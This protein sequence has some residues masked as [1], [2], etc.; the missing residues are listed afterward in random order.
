M[1]H[2]H[3]FDWYGD[4]QKGLLVKSRAEAERAVALAPELA[5]AHAVRAQLWLFLYLNFALA[6]ADVDRALAISPNDP[7]SL[8]FKA[9]LVYARGKSSLAE[10]LSYLRRATELDPLNIGAWSRRGLAETWSGDFAAAETSLARALAIAPANS[11]GTYYSTLLRILQGK[12]AAALELARRSEIG[13]IRLTGTAMAEHDLGH[14]RESRA[15]LDEM[16]SN[17]NPESTAAYQSPRSAPGAASAT[18]RYTGWSAHMRCA[19]KGSPIS[20]SIS[21]SPAFTTSRASRR[22]SRR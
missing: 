8:S 2:L 13:W 16:I 11:S 4:P 7:D 1:A 19:T 18:A 12:P 22:C 6:L 21:S 5:Q 20:R 14:E 10:A 15:A 9:E 3:L 17:D